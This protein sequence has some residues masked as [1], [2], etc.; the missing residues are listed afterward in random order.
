MA[1]Y[2]IKEQITQAVVA[3]LKTISIANGYTFDI[4]ADDVVR[5]RRTGELFVPKDMGIS[6]L[7][8]DDAPSP[9]N[10]LTGNPPI[11]GRTLTIQCDLVIRLSEKSELPMDQV[12]NQFEADV[13]VAV[14]DDVQWAG[15]AI[16]SRLGLSQYPDGKNGVEGVT[17]FIE[18]DYRVPENDPYTNGI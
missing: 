13:I 15:L 12:L 2:P 10:D 1:D 3:Q 8:V 4:V 11:V 6:V 16:D 7:Q 5:P 9:E 18:I 14:F 17:V